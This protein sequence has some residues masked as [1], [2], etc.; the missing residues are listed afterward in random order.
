A[1]T[2]AANPSAGGV[3]GGISAEPTDRT[4]AAAR[5][6]AAARFIR[7]AN[8][9]DPTAYLILRALRWGELRASGNPPD[10]RVLDAPPSAAR[11]QLRAL[12][13]DAKWPELLDAAET[14]MGTPAGRGWLDIQ[15]YALTACEALGADYERV[16][17]ALRDELRLVLAAVPALPEMSLMD[18]LPTANPETRAW[19][20][21]FA[22]DAT[23][24]AV[25]SGAAASA[26]RQSSSANGD[27]RDKVFE[28]ASSEARA[29]NPQKAMELLKRELEREQSRRGRW[30][31]QGQLASIMVDHGLSQVAAPIL[32]ELVL[33]IEAHR[34][35]EWEASEV[36]AQPLT[37]L[38][39][40]LEKLEGDAARRHELYLRICR[41]DPMAAI[42]FGQQ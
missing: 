20:A 35:E 32:E 26:Q 9:T 25:E 30:L 11:M 23:A 40:C 16:A 4:D 1:A 24:A 42:G 14:L 12:L 7:R 2:A 27:G 39:R 18:D 15:R 36:V 13:L 28:R 21:Q 34:L 19:L 37:L 17:T 10:P 3:A 5:A 33:S 8:P 22:S 6:V 41:L 29:G 38:Y 31:R